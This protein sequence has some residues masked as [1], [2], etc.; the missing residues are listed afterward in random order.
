MAPDTIQVRAELE[1]HAKSRGLVRST[2]KF[3]EFVNPRGIT[4]S[5]VDFLCLPSWIPLQSKS[6]V[7][8]YLFIQFSL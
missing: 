2:Q 5:V 3:K 6:L 7:S 4:T 8:L 1:A